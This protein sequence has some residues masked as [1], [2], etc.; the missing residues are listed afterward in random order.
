M[1]G[2]WLL[3]AGGAPGG[4]FC[5][6]GMIHRGAETQR[7]TRTKKKAAIAANPAHGAPLRANLR[8]DPKP[9]RFDGPPFASVLLCVSAPLR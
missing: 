3:L 7:K 5:G 1:R 4:A 8:N 6:K 2:W 9:A